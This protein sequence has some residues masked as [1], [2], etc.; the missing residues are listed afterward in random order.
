MRS[1]PV[2]HCELCKHGIAQFESDRWGV[3]LCRI[4]CTR[5]AT[6]L[7]YYG[8]LFDSHPLVTELLDGPFITDSKTHRIVVWT[9]D[10]M[11]GGV[12][13]L[14]DKYVDSEISD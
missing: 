3:R 12:R 10:H 7:H 13:V 1:L 6:W 11:G 4:C 2:Y 9:S 14:V 8:M 5:I